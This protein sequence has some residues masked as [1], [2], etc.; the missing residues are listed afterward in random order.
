MKGRR[1]IALLAAALLGGTALAQAD[2]AGDAL[3][4]ISVDGQHVAGNGGHA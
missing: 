3:F 1:S 2:E 4:S